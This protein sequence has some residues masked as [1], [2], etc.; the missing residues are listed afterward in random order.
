MTGG[1]EGQCMKN[2][3]AI[4]TL[5]LS[6]VLF[7]AHP[8]LAQ[9]RS[10]SL[11]EGLELDRPAPK[12]PAEKQI[13]ADILELQSQLR[14]A[15]I[16]RDRNKIASFFADDATVTL[17]NGPVVARDGRIDM[18]MGPGLAFERMDYASQTIRALGDRGAVALVNTTA[19]IRPTP[20][21][22]KGIIRV[23]VVYRK[24]TVSQG[25]HGWQLVS[26]LGIFI[27]EKAAAPGT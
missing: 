15:A 13:E 7:G 17:A 5:L 6:G 23:M 19:F 16:A 14:A 3:V 24:G 11:P 8:A 1:W 12:S 22:P 2:N 27:P 20:D 25:Y 4:C 21:K 10:D 9:S 26:E 18:I